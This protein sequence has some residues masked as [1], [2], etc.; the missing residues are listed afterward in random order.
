MAKDSN[1]FNQEEEI[2]KQAKTVLEKA[3]KNQSVTVNDFAHLVEGQLVELGDFKRLLEGYQRMYKQLGVLVRTGDKQQRRL[4][5][6]NDQLEI[7][8]QFIKKTFG[9]YLSDDIAEFI[10]E[11]PEG[12]S[13]GGETREVSIL[14]SDLRGFMAVTERLPAQSVV[15]I[16]NIYLGIMTEIIYK[17][18][19]TIDEFIG[20]GILAIFGAPMAQEDHARQAV[21]C[22]MEMQLAIKKVNRKNR[23][24]GL[25]EVQMGIGINTGELVVGNIGSPRRVKYGIV[26]RNVNLTSRIEAYT[27]PGQTYISHSTKEKCGPILDINDTMEVE[28][29]GVDSPITIYEVTGIRGGFNLSVPIPKEPVLAPVTPPIKVNFS[30]VTEKHVDATFHKGLLVNYG[31]GLAD[32]LSERKVRKFSDLKVLLQIDGPP[33]AVFTLYGKVRKNLEDDESTKGFQIYFGTVPPEVEA[34]LSN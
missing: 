9:R 11:S 12:A 32:I 24:N 3:G 20:D 22:A 28:P 34:V 19:G 2:L 10:L 15:K 6:L 1:L 33:G 5:K 13:L 25:P 26:G 23:Q 29:K 21:A 7:R 27:G 17:Y 8:N 4:N 30:F 18:G 16:L 14:M 31:D